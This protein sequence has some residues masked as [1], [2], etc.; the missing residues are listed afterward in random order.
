MYTI[1]LNYIGSVLVCTARGWPAPE[2]EWLKDGQPLQ[3]SRGVLSESSTMVATVSARLTWISEFAILDTGRYECVVRKPNTV[4]VVTSQTVQLKAGAET[5]SG[6]P[7]SCS[8]N[9]QSVFF[10]IRVFGTECASAILSPHIAAEFHDELVNVIKTECNCQVTESELEMLGSPQCSSK[11]NGATVFR[12]KIETLSQSRTEQLFCALF[13]WQQKSPLILIDDH[14]RAVDNTC[15]LKASS[16]YDS[17]ECVA[18]LL[19]QTG[20][21]TTTSKL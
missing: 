11:V 20:Q 8:V 16:S 14:L 1:P 5:P 7:P 12:G 18:P 2:V 6:T 10:Q 19:H 4:V 21:W 9:E 13:S 15:S 17:E 3:G